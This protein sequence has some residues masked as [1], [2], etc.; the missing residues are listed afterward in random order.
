MH[1]WVTLY[2]IAAYSGVTSYEI[3]SDLVYKKL[4]NFIDCTVIH[5]MSTKGC[6]RSVVW[7]HGSSYLQ[8]ASCPCPSLW[9]DKHRLWFVQS[10]CWGRVTRGPRLSRRLPA[11]ISTHHRLQRHEDLAFLAAHL[12]TFQ[13]TIDYMYT[14]VCLPWRLFLMWGGGKT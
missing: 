3:F 14:A 11:H 5:D 4:D 13:H 8:M 10:V 1:V 7:R 6:Q 12:H 9:F 2:K